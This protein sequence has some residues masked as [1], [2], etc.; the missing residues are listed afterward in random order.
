MRL[1]CL[2]AT[3]YVSL[4]RA[5]AHTQPRGLQIVW[6]E[7]FSQLHPVRK[8]QFAEQARRLLAGETLLS[9]GNRPVE[10]E[11]EDELN[12]KMAAVDDDDLFF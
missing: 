12:G 2:A 5:C 3:R 1:R 9:N 10:E 7:Q 6:R 11:E 4:P 8:G